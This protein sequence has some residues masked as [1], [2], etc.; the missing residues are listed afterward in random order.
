MATKTSLVG[1]DSCIGRVSKRTGRPMIS[2]GDG[3]REHRDITQAE[4]FGVRRARWF[5]LLNTIC[6]YQ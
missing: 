6:V 4:P 1:H 2:E 3:L 5:A